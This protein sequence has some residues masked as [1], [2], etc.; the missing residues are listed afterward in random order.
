MTFLAFYLFERE[1]VFFV[2]LFGVLLFFIFFDSFLFARKNTRKKLARVYTL[3][4]TLVYILFIS[5]LRG[6]KKP[7]FIG[8]PRFKGGR[9]VPFRWWDCS[10]CML[11]GGGKIP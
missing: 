6:L 10:V 9:I 2:M 7:V 8:V 5:C 3:V 4:K 1:I 11:S